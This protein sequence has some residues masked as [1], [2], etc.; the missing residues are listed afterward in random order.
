MTERTKDA[1]LILMLIALPVGC[2]TLQA[3][4]PVQAPPARYQANATTT[5]EFI[6]AEAVIPR[7]LERGAQ[8]LANACSDRTLI[9]ITNPCSYQG[10]SFAKRLCHE[11]AHANGWDAAHSKPI[12]PASES[13]QALA[14]KR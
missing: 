1:F 5:V 11:L 7:C 9:T 3:L 4:D 2:A 13:P 10:E 8:V 14:M 6:S 12:P